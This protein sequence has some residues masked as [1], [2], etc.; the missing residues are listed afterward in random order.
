MAF[1]R[2]RWVGCMA[3][4]LA[5]RPAASNGAAEAL[6]IL[7]APPFLR[8]PVVMEEKALSAALDRAEAALDRLERSLMRVDQVRGRDDELRDRVREAV[9]ELD[10]LIGRAGG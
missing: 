3:A 5:A 10:Q 8:N 1:A 6:R 2:R 7:P 9:A 4:P